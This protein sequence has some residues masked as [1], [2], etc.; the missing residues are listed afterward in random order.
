VKLV[1]DTLGTGCKIDAAHA[2]SRMATPNESQVMVQFAFS[3]DGR[4]KF[5]HDRVPHCRK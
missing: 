3:L 2:G 4:H 5:A 1:P